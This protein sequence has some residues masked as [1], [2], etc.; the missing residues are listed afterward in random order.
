MKIEALG[1][2]NENG[3]LIIH[4][5]KVFTELLLNLRNKDVEITIS[6]RR[7]KRSGN[8]NRYYFGVL[9]PCIQQGLFDTQGEWLNTEEVHAFLKVHFNYKEITNTSNG[10]MVKLGKTT[11]E[12][13]TIEFEEYQDK[14]RIFADEFLN[15]I[16]PLPNQQASMNYE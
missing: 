14:C 6:K 15:V 4:N 12:L 7:K 8:Q 2:V 16:I 5:S 13:S 10:E 3:E 11:T 1:K 9:I